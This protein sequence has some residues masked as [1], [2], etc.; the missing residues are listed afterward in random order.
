MKVKSKTT[1]L[2]KE[3]IQKRGWIDLP[4]DGTSMYPLIKKGN[5]CRFVSCKTSTMKKGDIILFQTENGTLVAHRFLK[6]HYNSNQ[7][8][9][10][11][12]GDTNLGLDEP[13][14]DEKIIGR[15]VLINKGKMNVKV[16]NLYA[17][18]WCKVILFFPILSA[19][20]RNYINKKELREL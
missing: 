11:F 8:E 13:I 7:V 16:T 19:L 2:I 17:F 9:Y 18:A 10:L 3:V 1:Y 5:I 15:L 6:S 12:K 14:K 20:L 4:A